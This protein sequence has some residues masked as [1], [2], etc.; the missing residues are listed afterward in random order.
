MNTACGGRLSSNFIFLGVRL[1]FLAFF[2]YFLLTGVPSLLSAVELEG[3]L[4]FLGMM[5]E[6]S[7]TSI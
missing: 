7:L 3:G 1:S 5:I 6:G 4:D 2:T